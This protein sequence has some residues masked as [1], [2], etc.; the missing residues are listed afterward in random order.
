MV[1]HEDAGEPADVRRDGDGQKVTAVFDQAPESLQDEGDDGA[2][3]RNDGGLL[4]PEDGENES[5]GEISVLPLREA[6][7][8]VTDQEMTG[9]RIIITLNNEPSMVA[10]DILP[11]DI[12]RA[13]TEA[14]GEATFISRGEFIGQLPEISD[15]AVLGEKFVVQ[16]W[17][18]PGV[19]VQDTGLSEIRNLPG[20]IITRSDVRKKQVEI[21]EEIENGQPQIVTRYGSPELYLERADPQTLYD[22]LRITRFLNSNE[23]NQAPQ[24]V[25]HDVASGE[26]Y[27][28]FTTSG[29]IVRLEGI[30]L[31]AAYQDTFDTS[32]RA[33]CKEFI[34]SQ[35]KIEEKT[36]DG[37]TLL[38]LNG[39]PIW[40]IQD[41]S[42][43]PNDASHPQVTTMSITDFNAELQPPTGTKQDQTIHITHYDRPKYVATRVTSAQVDQLYER[44]FTNNDPPDAANPSTQPS[45]PDNPPVIL[46]D[47]HR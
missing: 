4:S 12:E 7:Y 29:R 25:A 24:T 18:V 44:L 39:V 3:G 26:R 17:G 33:T 31:N 45:G 1:T 43:F 30:D 11:E 46:Y 47:N 37:D 6:R 35:A 40:R 41:T 16:R 15:R 36:A 2:G 20:S 28:I 5:R 23:L 27:I 10:Y 19:T 34:H 9:K 13:R 38:T 32:T 8:L 14:Y 22:A 21:F 42:S